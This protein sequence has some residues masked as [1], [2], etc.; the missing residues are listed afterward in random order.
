MR[1]LLA[2]WAAMVVA[3]LVMSTAAAGRG[4]QVSPLESPPRRPTPIGGPPAWPISP[5]DPGLPPA[6]RDRASKDHASDTAREGVAVTP[7]AEAPAPAPT[8]PG[9]VRTPAAPRSRWPEW[10]W[11]GLRE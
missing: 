9:A 7:T 8:A 3:L 10:K 11:A 2:L 6:T 4:A 5:L 1:K